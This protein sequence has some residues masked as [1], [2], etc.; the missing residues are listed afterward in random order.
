[1]CYLEVMLQ[2]FVCKMW[3]R[4]IYMNILHNHFI[5]IF[6]IILVFSSQS[7]TLLVF[8]LPSGSPLLSLSL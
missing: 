6:I 3:F 7:S 1:M 5:L 4:K 2:L 8:H